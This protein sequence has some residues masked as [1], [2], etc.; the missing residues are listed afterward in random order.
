MMS[1]NVPVAFNLTL[2]ALPDVVYSFLDEDR[3]WSVG[4]SPHPGVLPGHRQR[5]VEPVR[6]LSRHHLMSPV[7]GELFKTLQEAQ[8]CVR[9]YSLAARFQVVGG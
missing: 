1:S 6:K 3:D 7:K 5:L 4:R 9:D 2:P 8:D